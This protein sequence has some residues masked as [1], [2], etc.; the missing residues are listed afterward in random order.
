MGILSKFMGAFVLNFYDPILSIYLED[1]V[2]MDPTDAFL[3]FSVISL[4][5][6]L[7]SYLYGKWC[8]RS[9]L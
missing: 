9:N 7:G 1:G 6:A 5:F 8:E 4:L 3:G 2:G